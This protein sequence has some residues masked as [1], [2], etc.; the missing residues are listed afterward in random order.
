MHKISLA[1]NVDRDGITMT[2]HGEFLVPS[3]LYGQH[4]RYEVSFGDDHSMPFC[5][6]N[7]WQRSPYLCKHFFAIFRRFPAFSWESLSATY[8]NSPFMTLDTLS[9][10]Q[11]S[12]QAKQKDLM[13]KSIEDVGDVEGRMAVHQ[14]AASIGTECSSSNTDGLAG[15]VIKPEVSATNG[16]ACRELLDDIK[17]LTFL[18]EDQ[19]DDISQLHSHLTELRAEVSKSVPKEKEIF[20]RR[21]KTKPKRKVKNPPAP[22]RKRKVEASSTDDPIKEKMPCTV[23][24]NVCAADTQN[25]IEEEVVTEEVITEHI[26]EEPVPDS[27]QYQND[28]Q[29]DDGP[30][31]SL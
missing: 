9:V 12:Q 24:F 26:C 20:Q 10:Y 27:S 5:T 8:R 1:E 11:H 3:E 4:R 15:M 30:L 19:P 16:A 29:P 13:P 2:A 22:R 28:K 21:D 25:I 6:C 18:L 7:E 17:N 14:L 23:S 31:L